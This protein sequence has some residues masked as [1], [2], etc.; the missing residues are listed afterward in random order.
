LVL[1]GLLVAGIGIHIF[2]RFHLDGVFD[3]PYSDCSYVFKDGQVYRDSEKG[4]DH[5]GTYARVGGRWICTS[6]NGAS[7]VDYFQSSLLGVRWFHPKF[8]GGVHFLPRRSFGACAE[9][10]DRFYIRI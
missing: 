9:L 10:L 1:L 5:V 3:D 6:L 2:F 4:R 7:G 8:D